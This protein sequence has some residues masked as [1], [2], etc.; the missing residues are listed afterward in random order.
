MVNTTKICT[1]KSCMKYSFT[2]CNF[3][4]DM[5]TQANT[6]HHVYWTNIQIKS[7]DQKHAAFMHDSLCYKIPSFC[8]KIIK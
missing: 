5:H 8:Y 7:K 3:T 2:L 1:C 4:A 6:Q